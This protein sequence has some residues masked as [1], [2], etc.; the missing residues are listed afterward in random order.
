MKVHIYLL[1]IAAILSGCGRSDG[2]QQVRRQMH[3]AKR[4]MYH[5]KNTFNPSEEELRFMQEHKIERLYVRFDDVSVCSMLDEEDRQQVCPSATVQFKSNVFANDYPN[6]IVPT[7]FIEPEAIAAI[8]NNGQ[9]RTIARKMVDRILNICSYYEIPSEKVA[10]LQLDCDWTTSTEKPFFDFCK[11]VRLVMPDSMLLSSTIRLHQL[12]RPA[13]P[14]DYGVLML[15]NTN[16]LRDPS[17]E[18]SIL[19]ANDVKPYLRNVSY[20]LPL[21]LAY[22]IYAWNLWF[23]NGTFRGILRSAS[24]ADSLRQAG[25][26]IRHEEVSFD[27]ILNVKRLVEKHLPKP[28]HER[29]TILYHLDKDNIKRYSSHEIETLYS[30]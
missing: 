6:E 22:P 28:S 8:H 5:W 20:D 27:E 29:S 19:S 10:E 9:S 15:Y 25:E 17:I 26:K 7:V 23:S 16:N 24:Q 4:A 1:L 30:H 21:D 2:Q 12:H 11:D 14:V 18:N 3:T 13:P